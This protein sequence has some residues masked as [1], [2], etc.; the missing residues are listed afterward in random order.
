MEGKVLI[1]ED[2]GDLCLVLGRQ[3]QSSGYECKGVES[4]EEALAVASHFKPDVVL[5]DIHFA[6][7]DGADFVQC[8]KTRCE[9]SG[10]KLPIIVVMSA[11]AEDDIVSYFLDEGAMAFLQKPYTR[12]QLLNTLKKCL[13]EEMLTRNAA[14]KEGLHVQH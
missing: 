7:Y 9:N 11:H 6:H 4:V 12:Y 2:D 13:R 5:L 3:L 8:Y 10:E 14:W 1:V